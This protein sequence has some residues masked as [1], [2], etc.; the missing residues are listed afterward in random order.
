MNWADFQ[1][2]RRVVCI[3]HYEWAGTLVNALPEIGRVYTVRAQKNHPLNGELG[4]RLKELSIFS[5]SPKFTPLD[6]GEY[7]LQAR[8]FRPLDETR[9]DQFRKLLAPTPEKAVQP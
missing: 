1:P 3:S 2:G 6:G 7:W 4:I 9:L 5:T 8:N